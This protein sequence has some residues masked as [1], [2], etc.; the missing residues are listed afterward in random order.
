MVHFF[1]GV[2]SDMTG[3]MSTTW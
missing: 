3:S 2:V 1:T